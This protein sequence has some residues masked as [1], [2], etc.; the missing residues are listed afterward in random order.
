M[1]DYTDMLFDDFIELHGDRV[2]GD[3][4]A[5]VCGLGRFHGQTVA[6]VGQHKGTTTDEKLKRNFGMARPW[7]YRKALRIYRMAERLRYP[8]V[9]FVDTP[10]ADPGIDSEQHGQGFGIGQM[11]LASAGLR[12]PIFSVVLSEG[13]SGGALAIAA[14]DWVTMF[15][16]AVYVICPPERCAEIL[17]RD[18]SKREL[19]AEAMKVT[20]ADLLELGI[21][22]SILPEPPGGAHTNPAGAAEVLSGEI[23]RFLAGCREGAWNLARRQERFRRAGLWTEL[24]PP[25]NGTS[26]PRK[27]DKGAA[28]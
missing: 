17:W 6:V 3:D 25:A 12:T 11:L 23:D 8:V 20:A 9:S 21:I 15:E 18:V 5:M 10:A 14:G 28:G 26:A 1:L 27:R 2:C 13:G 22:D 16:N 24:P 4:P 7:G 19:A